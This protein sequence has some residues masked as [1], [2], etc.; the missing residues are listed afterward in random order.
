MMITIEDTKDLTLGLH[1]HK[2]KNNSNQHRT[3]CH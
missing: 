3:C 1:M 2:R